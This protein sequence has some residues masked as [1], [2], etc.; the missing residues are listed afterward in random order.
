MAVHVLRTLGQRDISRKRP[1]PGTRVPQR[2]TE[3]VIIRDMSEKKNETKAEVPPEQRVVAQ[4]ETMKIIA[5][6]MEKRFTLKFVYESHGDMKER[7]VEPY[8]LM[9]SNK[10][11]LTVYAFCRSANAIRA[12]TVSKIVGIQKTE[13]QY[14]PKWPIENLV[15]VVKEPEKTK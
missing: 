4:T 3:K 7:E 12:F 13:T 8:K 5:E 14:E 2:P 15:C 9:V 1:A 11:E 6:C 10:G